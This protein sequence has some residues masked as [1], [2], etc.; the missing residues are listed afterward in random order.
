V[1]G[2]VVTIDAMSCQR[3]IARRVLLDKTSG[4]IP[5]FKGNLGTP[6]E[7]VEVFAAFA[8]I[9]WPSTR[10]EERPAKLPASVAKSPHG[11]MTS[12]QV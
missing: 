10:P 12:W 8:T 11:T 6:R 1:E 5:A 3:D 7:D 2:A 9:E 4:Y